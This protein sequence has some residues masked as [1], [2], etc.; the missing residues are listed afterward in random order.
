MISILVISLVGFII[1]FLFNRI[2]KQQVLK[3][4]AQ[5]RNSEQKYRT[6][7]ENLNVGIY[8]NTPGTDGKFIEVNPAFLKIFDYEDKNEVLQFNVSDFYFNKDDSKKID[9]YFSDSDFVSNKGLLLKKKD[10]SPIYCS[11]SEVAVKKNNKIIHYDGIIENITERKQ[12][13]EEIIKKSKEL[14][15]QYK[16]SEKQRIATSVVLNDLN[17]TTKN[18]KAEII[19]RNKAEKELKARMNELEIFNDV[20]VDREIIIN[21]LRKEINELLMKLGGEEKYRIVT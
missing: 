7:T 15:K 20:T 1:I 16:I 14:K 11:I 9:T 8:R 4:T 5:L 3:R 19:E 2:L 12:T 13:D 18:L 10:G 6:L 17:K 21:E